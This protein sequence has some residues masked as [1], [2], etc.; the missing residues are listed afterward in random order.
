MNVRPLDQLQREMQREMQRY[1]DRR[2]DQERLPELPGPGD[3]AVGPVAV[4]VSRD[5]SSQTGTVRLISGDP[6]DTWQGEESLEISGVWLGDHVSLRPGELCRVFRTGLKDRPFGA[7]KLDGSFAV[8]AQKDGGSEGSSSSTCSFTY[9]VKDVFNNT[10]ATGLT[11][12][13]RR[14]PNIKHL[15]ES[16]GWS[17][18][19]ANHDYD[20][21][22]ALLEVFAE[23]QDAPPPP[24]SAPVTIAKLISRNGGDPDLGTVQRITG[25]P[26]GSWGLESGGQISNVWLE[27]QFSIFVG[28]LC[29]VKST[30]LSGRPYVATP[31][32]LRQPFLVLCVKDGGSAGG[33][34]STCSFTYTV[35]DAYNNVL[36]TELSPTVLRI[37]NTKYTVL[38]SSYGMAIDIGDNDV[39]LLEVF[40]ERQSGAG[41]PFPITLSQTG[42]SQGTETAAASW[43]YTV[44]SAITGA[45][46]GTGVDPTTDNHKWVRLNLGQMTA[47]TYG[48]ASYDESSNLVIGW[49]NEQ[50]I[51][52]GCVT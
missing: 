37:A 51:K 45:T 47:A 28:D 4:V 31:I 25:D 36:G 20:Q 46:L 2:D 43:T 18:A 6:A 35:K 22:L 14:T 49:I 44:T 9:T 27:D 15:T 48:F 23:R 1:R 33:P 5:P 40:K 12:K 38:A 19:L 50:E 21:G 7:L 39:Q 13:K 17:Y 26:A 3:P 34:G 24:D 16:V 11:P 42:G 52:E 10:I 30:G 8:L 41:R 29:H 32:A